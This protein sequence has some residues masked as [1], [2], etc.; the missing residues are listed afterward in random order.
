MCSQRAAHSTGTGGV[1]TCGQGRAA[2]TPLDCRQTPTQ[3]THRG[4]ALATNAAGSSAACSSTVT[5]CHTTVQSQTQASV[6]Q[7]QAMHPESESVHRQ[8]LGSA[9][10]WGR[11]CMFMVDVHVHAMDAWKPQ[12]A[13]PTAYRVCRAANAKRQQHSVWQQHLGCNSSQNRCTI[14]SA[15]VCVWGGGCQIAL[16]AKL[17]C[18]AGLGPQLNEPTRMPHSNAHCITH[19]CLRDAAACGNPTHTHKTPRARQWQARQD[20]PQTV[21]VGIEPPHAHKTHRHSV[22][23]TPAAATPQN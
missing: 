16:S 18:W 10:I 5:I 6:I 21:A 8:R 9:R 3:V 17:L 20:T 1:Q 4:Y 11:L 22:M 15:C 13:A 19:K 23:H 7:A 2:H 14:T 12:A